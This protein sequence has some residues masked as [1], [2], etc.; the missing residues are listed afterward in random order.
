MGVF[1]TMQGYPWGSILETVAPLFFYGILPRFR[2]LLALFF[3]VQRPQ[4][5]RQS[6]GNK[7]SNWGFA[8]KL[9]ALWLLW[10]H[11]IRSSEW[12]ARFVYGPIDVLVGMWIMSQDRI[13]S[14]L[15]VL[16]FDR[17]ASDTFKLSETVV[18]A[19]RPLTGIGEIVL[20]HYGW[21]SEYLTN[22]TTFAGT[23]LLQYQKL[24]F[25]FLWWIIC[26]LY[27]PG[28][29]WTFSL[30]TTSAFLVS[31]LVAV[32]ARVDNNNVV[33]GD[34]SWVDTIRSFL[35]VAQRVGKKSGARTENPDKDRL[36]RSF[37]DINNGTAPADN[38][39]T[40]AMLDNILASTLTDILTKTKSA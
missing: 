33:A 23:R 11:S 38:T 1:E 27:I 8:V 25:P 37:S 9:L 3:V 13:R 14:S 31:Y 34:V 12:K 26:L 29:A 5:S 2:L 18:D 15:S 16:P 32:R 10:N 7:F 19:D 30:L 6:V 40:M 17:I 4:P 36:Q 24:F 28:F 22:I 39:T 20:A 21:V 35:V